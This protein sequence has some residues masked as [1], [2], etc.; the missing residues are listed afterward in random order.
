MILLDLSVART[1][2]TATCTCSTVCERAALVRRC[3]GGAQRSPRLIAPSVG[4]DCR[5]RQWASSCC[6]RDPLCGRVEHEEEKQGW[7]GKTRSLVGRVCDASCRCRCRCCCRCR[8]RYRYRCLLLLHLSALLL[9]VKHSRW[10][11]SARSFTRSNIVPAGSAPCEFGAMR[12]P[13]RGCDPYIINK[14]RGAA[15]S[16]PRQYSCLALFRL[17]LP[18]LPLLAAHNLGRRAPKG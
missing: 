2:N 13:A 6:E 3:R 15:P 17:I 10:V 7:K 11:L 14:Q 9:R 1:C 8:C 18:L 4:H 12:R 5:G 16:S